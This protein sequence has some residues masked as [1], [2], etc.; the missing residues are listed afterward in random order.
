VAVAALQEIHQLSDHIG[1]RVVVVLA[2][3]EQLP[4][5][6]QSA[7]RLVVLVLRAALA[8]R[9]GLGQRPRLVVGQAAAAVAAERQ[10][11]P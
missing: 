2:Q 3:A 11:P 7:L 9:R 8:V 10:M 6:H 1:E 4:V 5:R